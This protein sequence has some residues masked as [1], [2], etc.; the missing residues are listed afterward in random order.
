MNKEKFKKY[1]IFSLTT[2]VFYIFPFIRPTDWWPAAFLSL[3]IP[4]FLFINFILVIYSIKE[5][6][7]LGAIPLLTLII[8]Y[9]FIIGI[10]SLNFSN[11]PPKESISVLSYN[12]R[13]FNNYLKKRGTST[14]DMISWTSNN[15]AD[16][17]CIQE[18]FNDS[19]SNEFNSLKK[20]RKKNFFYFFAPYRAKKY[21]RTGM[22]ILSKFPIINT[23]TVYFKKGSNN[24]IIY[25]DI[26]ANNDT[27]R[28]YNIHLQ[29]M[30]MEVDSLF[31]PQKEGILEEVWILLKKYKKGT[32]TRTFQVSKL[33]EHI[34]KSPFKSI[35]CG[36][37]NDVPVS[38]VYQSIK[39]K[40][41]NAYEE[42]GGGLGLT[43][44]SFLPLRIDNHFSHP[45]IKIVNYKVHKDI[46]YS[47]HYPVSAT[48]FIE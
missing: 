22:A 18:F 42:A 31:N 5:K 48:Y 47:D 12:V 33:L 40:M 7:L 24:Q 2:I 23:G 8:G 30:S 41:K 15:E 37:L 17:K 10:I 21:K 38:F 4:I 6:S 45:L 16:I 1:L 46:K 26:V 9:R 3:I 34:E 43:Y 36:D 13:L 27:F 29:S 11:P 14:K 28:V 19:E 20:I 39:G 25:S 35:V 44:R 32:Q